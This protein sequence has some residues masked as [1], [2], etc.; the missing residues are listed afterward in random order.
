MKDDEE[1]IFENENDI[2]LHK[3]SESVFPDL[4]T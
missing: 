4:K 1:T 2:D 3:S